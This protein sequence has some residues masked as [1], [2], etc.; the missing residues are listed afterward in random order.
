MF[1]SWCG[2]TEGL[3]PGV[4]VGIGDGS[5]SVEHH[6]SR[7]HGGVGTADGQATQVLSLSV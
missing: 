5:K 3:V 7:E 1:S 2:S 4:D 6:R